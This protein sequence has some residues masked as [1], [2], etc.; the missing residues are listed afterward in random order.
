M[1]ALFALAMLVAACSNKAAP[2]MLDG[3]SGGGDSLTLPPHC[4]CP[5]GAYCDLSTN[6]CHAG[7][8][9]D[10]DCASGQICDTS[11]TCRA[12][13]RVDK[14]CPQSDCGFGSC[15]PDGTCAVENYPDGTSCGSGSTTCSSDACAAGVCVHSS[16]PDGT[17]CGTSSDPCSAKRCAAGA[18]AVQTR[19]DFAPC[20]P[21]GTDKSIRQQ[22]CLAGTCKASRETCEVSGGSAIV[23][24]EP[25]ETTGM[26]GTACSCSTTTL[27]LTGTPSHAY[28]CTACG[29][30]QPGGGVTYV[31]CL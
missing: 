5:M 14:D 9:S 29:Q 20:D 28:S 18:C 31:Y 24:D 1:K 10:K 19:P 30:Y 2:T 27:I 12:G 23:L 25:G 22:T 7:C 6:T 8:G 17:V 16:A 11:H 13:C 21:M 4:P 3:S 26:G 15:T